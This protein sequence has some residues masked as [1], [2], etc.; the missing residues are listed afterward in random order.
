MWSHNPTLY[1]LNRIMHITAQL[2]KSWDRILEMCDN[3]RMRKYHSVFFQK[4]EL[5][6]DS[7]YFSHARSRAII[8]RIRDENTVLLPACTCAFIT[9]DHIVLQNRLR[10]KFKF[11]VKCSLK[12]KFFIYYQ[13]I[14]TYLLSID[15]PYK[16][17]T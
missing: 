15:I 4:L 1:E 8:S 5:K 10:I 3:Y 6:R 9:F 17:K 13:Y 14:N 12:W 7:K 11:K 2:C 16:S